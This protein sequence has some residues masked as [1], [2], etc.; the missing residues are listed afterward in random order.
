LTQADRSEW[1]TLLA[2]VSDKKLRRLM[3][4]GD[5]WQMKLHGSINRKI[6]QL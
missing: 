1:K 6:M 5:N 3:L 2:G 4:E